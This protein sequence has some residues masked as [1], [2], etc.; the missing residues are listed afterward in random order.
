MAYQLKETSDEI[1]RFYIYELFFRD[2]LKSLVYADKPETFEI[3]EGNIQCVIA[4]VRPQM[5]QKLV[6]NLAYR[7]EFIR[8][9]DGD[10]LHKIT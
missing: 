7:L 5:S 9:S 10:Y 2:Y 8:A 4:D 1:V 3:L 6:E